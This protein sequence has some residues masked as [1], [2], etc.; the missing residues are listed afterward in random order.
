MKKIHISVIANEDETTNTSFYFG[1][2]T[3]GQMSMLNH[4]LDILKQEIISRIKDAPKIYE[5][6][7]YGKDDADE[8]KEE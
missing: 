5:I 1:G 8:V 7:D 4:E 2:A 3:V 6:E